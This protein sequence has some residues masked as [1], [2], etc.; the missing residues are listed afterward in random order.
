MFAERWR[1]QARE[2]ERL[3][4]AAADARAR[5]RQARRALRERFE[6]VGKKKLVAGSFVA[7]FAVGLTDEPGPATARSLRLARTVMLV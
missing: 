3:G 7:G 2:V 6:E 4:A 5:S 1:R